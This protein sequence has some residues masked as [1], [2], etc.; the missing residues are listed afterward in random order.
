MLLLSRDI[1]FFVPVSRLD[2]F[3]F[4]FSFLFD[5]YILTF[6]LLIILFLIEKLLFKLLLIFFW[7]IELKKFSSLKFGDL[8][9]YK[10]SVFLI[11]V[12]ILFINEFKL[13]FPIPLFW[14]LLILLS[15]LKFSLF[16]LF[17]NILIGAKSL[18]PMFILI[19]FSLEL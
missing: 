17:L 19:K 6:L 18:P 11:F 3:K 1:L 13:L 10:L 9:V 5:S 2:K 4:W 8:L 12:L 16:L 15:C 14:V 7:L